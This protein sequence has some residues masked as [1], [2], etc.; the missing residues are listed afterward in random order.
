MDPLTLG[1]RPRETSEARTPPTFKGV[2][3]R[4]AAL[5]LNNYT[6]KK[7]WKAYHFK[8]WPT[9]HAAGAVII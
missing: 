3:M 7:S 4:Q 5:N 1:I 9:T 8:I 6:Q 2:N